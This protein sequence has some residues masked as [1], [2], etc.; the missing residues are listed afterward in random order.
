MQ[1]IGLQDSSSS[2][3]A[4][5]SHGVFSSRSWARDWKTVDSLDELERGVST[6]SYTQRRLSN[7]IPNGFTAVPTTP[8]YR[9]QWDFDSPFVRGPAMNR[10][11]LAS[12]NS[13]SPTPGTP[14]SS[15]SSIV[16]PTRTSLSR[17]PRY[18]HPI[19]STTEQWIQAGEAAR[20]RRRRYQASPSSASVEELV[21]TPD[22]FVGPALL[23]ALGMQ[24]ELSDTAPGAYPVDVTPP[25]TPTSGSSGSPPLT[26]T[27]PTTEYLPSGSSN[28]I[29]Y[30]RPQWPSPIMSRASEPPRP[31]TPMR[32]SIPIFNFSRSEANFA[33][34]NVGHLR[35]S[36]HHASTTTVMGEPTVYTVNEVRSWTAVVP[37]GGALR[38]RRPGVTFT[39]ET[40][41]IQAV[42]VTP[43][44]VP[45]SNKS[46]AELPPPPPPSPPKTHLS[47]TCGICQEHFYIDKDPLLATRSKPT[48][49]PSA[50][51]TYGLALPCPGAHKYCHDCMTS[52]VRT[53]VDPDGGERFEVR[54]PECPRSEEWRMG[55]EVAVKVLDGNLLEA[56]YFR[57]LLSSMEYFSCPDPACGAPIEEPSERLSSHLRVVACP[58]C[59]VDICFRCRQ[60]DHPGRTCKEANTNKSDTALYE[61]AQRLHWRRCPKCK[62]LVE[63]IEGCKHMTCRCGHEFCHLCGS[64]WVSRC[65]GTA[66]NGQCNG[67]WLREDVWPEMKRRRPS[68]SRALSEL[69]SFRPLRRSPSC[70]CP[71]KLALF[72]VEDDQHHGMWRQRLRDRLHRAFHS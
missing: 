6:G 54:C 4:F 37:S 69:F 3:V 16:H 50:A 27:S 15:S 66:G 2:S 65:T 55:D 63:R 41:R 40:P 23:E 33:R 44:V 17:T 72:D 25:A 34:G 48:T 9:T 67:E 45:E 42:D 11:P 71:P 10:P 36:S 24:S 57:R 47:A 12:S 56:W 46:E 28:P 26:P 5:Q 49:G 35:W 62:I 21:S 30:T 32:E 20:A 18:P 59:R 38:R 39:L 64:L 8:A 51:F 31:P 29:P 43:P 52:Y 14:S 22:P 60:L 58:R 68:H 70:P 53:K 7:R 13:G 19:S 1:L 61:L